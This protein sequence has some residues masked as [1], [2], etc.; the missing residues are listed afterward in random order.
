MM[1]S[2]GSVFCF[3]STLPPPNP[4]THTSTGM[5]TVLAKLTATCLALTLPLLFYNAGGVLN[6][7]DPS[8]NSAKLILR[9]EMDRMAGEPTD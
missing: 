6:C 2:S 8:F 3:L 1:F 4:S 7:L 9:S 5:Q